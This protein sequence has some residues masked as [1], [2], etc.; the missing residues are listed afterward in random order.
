[1]SNISDHFAPRPSAPQL[2]CA[3]LLDTSSSMGERLATSAGIVVPIDELNAALGPFLSDLRGHPKARAS[4]ELSAVTFGGRPNIVLD[5]TSVDSCSF[6]Q[7]R[8]NGE[9][10]LG[11]AVLQGLEMVRTRAEEHTQ[12]GQPPYRPWVVVLTDGKPT[13]SEDVFDRAA[14]AA[15]QAERSKKALVFIFTMD[16][17]PQTT[18]KL[19]K[20]THR[21]SFLSEAKFSSLFEFLSKSFAQVSSTAAGGRVALTPPDPKNIWLID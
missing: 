15:Q 13:D 6:P 12:Q 7:L 4:V 18:E 5:W 14:A 19:K 21:V 2:P 20:I 16:S 1:M 10:P 17:Q 11:A 9:T 3:L 8:A